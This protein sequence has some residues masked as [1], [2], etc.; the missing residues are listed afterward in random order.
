MFDDHT[1][2]LIQRHLEQVA[3]AEELAELDRLVSQR[4]EVADAL[5]E[6]SRVDALLTWHLQG[7]AE[8]GTIGLGF[9]PPEVRWRRYLVQA[10]IAAAILLV[11]VSLWCWLPGPAG[12]PVLA[13]SVEVNGSPATRIV[14]EAP[15][16]VVGDRPAVIELAGG[17]QVELVAS[18]AAVI[19]RPGGRKG[20]V[21]EL[22][23]G[24]GRFRVPYQT[25]RP[26]CVQTCNGSVTTLGTD[27]EVNLWSTQGKG[28]QDMSFRNMFV[29]MVAVATGM[30][31][32]DMPGQQQVLAAGAQKVF[33][34][35]PGVPKHKGPGDALPSGDV[36]GFTGKGGQPFAL[37]RSVPGVAGALELTAEQRQKIAAA[38]AE[39]IQ[40]EKVR[41][42]VVVAKLNPNA[43]Q[44]Q[45][46]EAQ[47]VVAVARGKLQQR[48]SQILTDE[49]KKLVARINAADAEV[50]QKVVD[51]MEAEQPPVKGDE[52]AMK[53]WREQLHQRIQTALQARVVA[54]LNPAQ[55]AAFDKAAAAQI[56]AE[57]AGKD[58]S[59]GRD[60]PT[61]EDKPKGPKK[62][63][64]QDKPTASKSSPTLATMLPR[65]P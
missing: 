54:L 27:F 50:R 35:E 39:T 36:L 3:T 53:R 41:A 8:G 15:L 33:G 61:G 40:S 24:G 64:S 23:E 65:M 25:G 34:A 43:T 1:Q 22:L 58:K 16:R 10:A 38:V 32:V 29:L 18:T 9:R 63:K 49:Q 30:V 51:A 21:F 44:A 11:G 60:K 42:A 48:V 59:K 14:E 46:E 52:Q 2:E 7:M 4:P 57:K 55:K 47:K 62:P 26:F 37:E 45:K 28:D 31:Q 12:Y 20:Q 13:G 19:R 56:A 6:A 5:W 17:A